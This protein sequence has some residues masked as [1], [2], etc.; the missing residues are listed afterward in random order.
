MGVNTD[1]L[2]TYMPKYYTA[3]DPVAFVQTAIS[4]GGAEKNFMIPTPTPDRKTAVELIRKDLREKYNIPQ[5]TRLTD[6]E[7]YL[8]AI[9]KNEPSMIPMM[10]DNTY[11]IKRLFSDQMAEAGMAGNDLFFSTGSG[12]DIMYNWQTGDNKIFTYWDE[13][14]RSK[15]IAICKTIKRWY[16]AGYINADVFG[17]TVRSKEL[18]QQ[19]KSG[20][21]FGNSLDVAG[22][23]SSAL[24]NGYTTDI[25]P[26]YTNGKGRRDSFTNNGWALSATTKN[27]ERVLM[28]MDLIMMEPAYV[29]LVNYGIL[30]ENYI[31]T[32]DNKLDYPPG[33]TADNNTYA[34]TAFWFT[35]KNLQLDSAAWTNEYS[36]HI[37][38]LRNTLA[39]DPL[40]G[41]EVTKDNVKTEDANCGTVMLQYGQ[42]LFV[43]AVRDV[44]AA[45]AE[46]EQ[47]LKIAGFDKLVGEAQ[48]QLN[49]FLEQGKD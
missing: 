18:F 46:L 21:G 41:F 30:G 31:V 12:L 43:G 32:N 28:A 17:Q 16:D 29:N 4:E 11:D 1:M 24:V 8:A 36:E 3:Q 34:T 45:F 42:P 25:I 35:D 49:A 9:K 40:I 23:V 13:P 14:W 7:P 37:R 39:N 48:R 33:V 5:I 2:K 22:N 6:I 27:P 19:G 44:D 20:V 38:S 15:A 10:M 47:K 26:I